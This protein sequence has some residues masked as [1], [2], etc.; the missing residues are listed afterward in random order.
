VVSATELVAEEKL[1][2]PCEVLTDRDAPSACDVP[3]DTLC[4]SETPSDTEVPSAVERVVEPNELC[5]DEEE[6]M[7]W[8]GVVDQDVPVP[9]LTWSVLESLMLSLAP[10]D[11]PAVS[12]PPVDVVRLA[13][14]VT[15]SLTPTLPMRLAPA[16]PPF[17][18][19]P[20]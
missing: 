1:D 2:E 9:L 13:P 16:C 7:E 11:V 10:L 8:A 14:S 20:L 3:R 19:D 6:V 4:A 15:L 12:E 17:V 18:R 5:E